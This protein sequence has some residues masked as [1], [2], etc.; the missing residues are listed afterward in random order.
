MARACMIAR[1]VIHKACPAAK[2]VTA[3]VMG[4]LKAFS[5][6][7]AVPRVTAPF[8]E[9]IRALTNHMLLQGV[10]KPRRVAERGSGG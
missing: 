1:A 3:S 8:E 9:G 7:R 6:H 10:S 5:R 2:I 4:D